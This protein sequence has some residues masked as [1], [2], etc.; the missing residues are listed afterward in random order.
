MQQRF[1][2]TPYELLNICVH[3][4]RKYWLLAGL[5]YLDMIWKSQL[6]THRNH[7]TVNTSRAIST[8]AK[9]YLTTLI[10]CTKND[11]YKYYRDVHKPLQWLRSIKI[12]WSKEHEEGLKIKKNTKWFMDSP[13]VSICLNVPLPITFKTMQSRHSTQSTHVYRSA[14]GCQNM[15]AHDAAKYGSC[16]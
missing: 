12:C 6:A 16:Y 8:K 2:T 4:I 3:P 7:L 9:S 15:F 11:W 1:P 10:I 5:G 13:S 14:A